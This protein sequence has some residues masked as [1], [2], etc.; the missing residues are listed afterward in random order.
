MI[1]NILSQFLF[2]Q[3]ILKTTQT[4]P[5]VDAIKNHQTITF[6]YYGPRKPKKD[7]VRPGRRIKVEPYAIGLSKKGKLILRAW[8]QPPSISKKGFQKTNWRTFM[9]ARMK[10]VIINKDTFNPNRPGYKEGD[11]KSMT[12]TYVS[13]D[14]SKTPKQPKPEKKITTPVAKPV[15]E[16]IKKV[17]VKKELPQPK[18]EKKLEPIKKE[19]PK[20][21]AKPQ[22]EK[23]EPQKQE[24]LKP[25]VLP[26]PKP[27]KK[28]EQ[29]QQEPNTKPEEDEINNLQEHLNKIKS[30]MYS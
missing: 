11:D 7:S 15:K 8:V 22:P 13:L 20:P 27:E 21:E 30:L 24:P 25:E 16:P 18:P 26:Q 23:I 10:N 17:P 29:I 19:L 28:P 12:V 4:K 14:R 6:D 5:I 2:E 1:E 3:N 9:V